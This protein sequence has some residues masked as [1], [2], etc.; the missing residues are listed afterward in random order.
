[1][2]E[3][4]MENNDLK[5]MFRENKV[6]FAYLF[7]SQASGSSGEKSDVDIAVMLPLEM[8]KEERFGL[9]LNLMGAIS[10]IFKKEVDIIVL[11]DIRS[12]FFKYIIMKEGKIIYQENEAS[13]ADFESKTLGMYFDFRPFLENYNKAYVKRS[14]Q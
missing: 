6:S 2:A 13:V 1:M 11:N 8:K 5:T 10:K 12:L 3:N 14:L 9:R 7:G 4:I